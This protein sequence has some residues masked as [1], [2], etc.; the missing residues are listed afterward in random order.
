MYRAGTEQDDR[1]VVKRPAC[2]SE[3]GVSSEFGL[4]ECGKVE[5]LADQKLDCIFFQY[6]SLN[7]STSL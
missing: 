1:G 5:C 7:P 4:R 2:G 6:L 3:P